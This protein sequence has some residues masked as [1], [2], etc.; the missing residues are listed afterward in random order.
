[1][2]DMSRTY[3]KRALSGLVIALLIGVAVVGASNT[4][5]AVN[6]GYPLLSIWSDGSTGQILTVAAPFIFFSLLG[7]SARRPW[8]VAFC[9]TVAFWAYYAYVITRPYEGGG[10]DIGLGILM[11]FSPLPIALASLLSLVSPNA[12][13][14]FPVNGRNGS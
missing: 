12:K 5:F 8:L 7:L 14:P 6:R 3:F 9:L 2:A 13:R 11:L 4:V 1:M 10:A